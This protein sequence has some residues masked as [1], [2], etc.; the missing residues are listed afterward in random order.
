MRSTQANTSNV[1]L[2]S[3]TI[4]KHSIV[5]KF[6]GALDGNVA[7]EPSKYFVTVNDEEVQVESASYSQSTFGVTLRLPQ[8]TLEAGDAVTV[9]YELRDT[10]GKA[11]VGKAGPIVAR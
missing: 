9:H 7:S 8:S 6:T 10:A 4:G 11:V 1:S 2:S 5:L 3:A